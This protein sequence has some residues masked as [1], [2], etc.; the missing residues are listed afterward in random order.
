MGFM[1]RECSI[2]TGLM[3][4]ISTGRIDLDTIDW[5]PIDPT[6]ALPAG[7]EGS[8]DD[9]VTS[10]AFTALAPPSACTY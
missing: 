3:S 2:P 10:I 4:M 9:S 6:T 5:R 1:V 7:T 8:A